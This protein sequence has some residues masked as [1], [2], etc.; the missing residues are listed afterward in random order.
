MLLLRTM[1]LQW[2]QV[3]ITHTSK[4]GFALMMQRSPNN[5]AIIAISQDPQETR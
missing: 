2:I 3:F 5:D 1:L 4:V